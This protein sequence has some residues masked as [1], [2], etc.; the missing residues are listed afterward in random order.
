VRKIF[1]SVAGGSDS[2]NQLNQRGLTSERP[3]WKLVPLMYDALGLLLAITLGW[4]AVVCVYRWFIRPWLVRAPMGTPFNGIVWRV[5]RLYCRVVHRVRYQGL[6][7]LRNQVDPGP[8]IVVS[9]H[10][11]AIDPILIQCGCRFHVRWMMASDMM[12][13]SLDWLWRQQEVIPVDRDGRDSTAARE[14]IR[15]LQA[16]EVVGIF[17]EGRI[18]W[19]PQEVRPFFLGVG[20]IVARS[21]ARVMLVCVSDTPR[22]RH[23]LESLFT[24]SHSLVRFI[25]VLDFTGERDAH[26]IT[27]TLRERIAQ[28][29]G[30]P[31]NDAPVP[32]AEDLDRADV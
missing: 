13:S 31:L 23:T 15:H 11:G 27:Q 14:A 26:V 20:L 32:N 22:T 21:R 1:H 2:L 3:A 12:A 24:P 7:E 29:A 6:E 5:G 9:N 25:E 10:T 16:G 4:I 28:E 18:V 30:W 19:P 17:P 8:M